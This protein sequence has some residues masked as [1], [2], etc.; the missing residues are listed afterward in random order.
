LKT[1]TD[2]AETFDLNHRLLD[3]KAIQAEFPQF[4]VADDDQDYDEP[5]AGLLPL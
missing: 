5:D 3:A 1:T 2:A 4:A